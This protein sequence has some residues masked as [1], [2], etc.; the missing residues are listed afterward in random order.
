MLKSTLSTTRLSGY[1]HLNLP[2]RK[3][4]EGTQPCEFSSP[5]IRNIEGN[6]ENEGKPPAFRIPRFGIHPD[7]FRIGTAQVRIE[8]E[9]KVLGESLNDTAVY[10]SARLAKERFN[11]IKGIY[12]KHGSEEIFPLLLK[13][14]RNDKGSEKKIRRSV[15]VFIHGY[16][17]SFKESIETGAE[18]AHLYSSDNHQLIPFV[19]SWPSDWGSLK[20]PGG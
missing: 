9:T 3:K 4:H 14:L 16:N 2:N 10:K 18:L 13:S 5:R 17:N 7:E 1:A 19:F 8:K 15:L 12:T 11:R 20:L 6:F